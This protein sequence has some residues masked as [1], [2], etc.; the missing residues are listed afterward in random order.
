MEEERDPYHTSM[1]SVG[2][3]EEAL[4]YDYIFN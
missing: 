4:H 1:F 2:G 3:V